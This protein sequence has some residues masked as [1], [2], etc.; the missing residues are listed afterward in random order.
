MRDTILSLKSNIGSNVSE[1]DDLN[2]KLRMQENELINLLKRLEKYES[3][4]RELSD[5]LMKE[6]SVLEQSE[7]DRRI[8]EEEINKEKQKNKLLW[9]DNKKLKQNE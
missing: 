4:E 1:A 8:K 9:S 2:N 5:L 7:S 6:K 3:S